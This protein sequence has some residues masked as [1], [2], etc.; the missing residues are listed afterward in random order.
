MLRLFPIFIFFLFLSA[1]ATV[2]DEDPTEGL[3][4]EEVY[5]DARE[6]LDEGE[7]ETAIEYYERLESRFPYGPYAEQAQLEVAYTYYKS[8]EYESAILAAERF[9][10]LH[11]DHRSA[12]YAYY[13]RGLARF[14]GEQSFMARWFSQDLT[15]RDP[16]SMREAFRYF[17]ELVSRFPDSR[18]TRDAIHRMHRLR[19]SLAQYEIHVANYYVRRYAFVAAANRAQHVVK[20][21]Q[22]TPV[23]AE[24]LSIMVNSYT[25]LG[26]HQLADDSQRVLDMNYPDY[27]GRER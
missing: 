4:V 16:K 23:V 1:C 13:L 18:Y 9:I 25:K 6:Y 14:D 17:S 8:Q 27:Q 5:R 7:Y 19:E 3:T 10:K 11:P 24:A 20:H 26:L 21:Y 22:G 12:D 2:D 15:E